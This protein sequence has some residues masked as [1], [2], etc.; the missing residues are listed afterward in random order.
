MDPYKTG[1]GSG[2]GTSDNHGHCQDPQVPFEM[3]FISH[4]LIAICSW[5]FDQSSPQERLGIG[6]LAITSSQ[7]LLP[8]PAA[9]PQIFPHEL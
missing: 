8:L 2:R 7:V 4:L 9:T 3:S 6:Y 1:R 5:K